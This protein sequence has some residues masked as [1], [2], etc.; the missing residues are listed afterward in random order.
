MKLFSLFTALVGS[1]DR[2]IRLADIVRSVVEPPTDPI[3]HIS[4]TR[5]NQRL[6]HRP[7]VKVGFLMEGPDMK[8]YSALFQTS[9]SV[10]YAKAWTS[11]KLGLPVYSSEP[12]E[13]AA[14][15][16]R[17]GEG[18]LNEDY[19]ILGPSRFLQIGEKIIAE[20]NRT[21]SEYACIFNG[22]ESFAFPISL[23]LIVE[24]S[25]STDKT[26]VADFL[27]GASPTSDFA[28][29]V[30]VFV[31]ADA[32]R[33]LFIGEETVEMVETLCYG[34]KTF[35]YFPTFSDPDAWI[36]EGSIGGID[37]AFELSTGAYSP[38]H[39]LEVDPQIID[40]VTQ[41]LLANNARQSLVNGMFSFCTNEAV[42]ALPTID[43]QFGREDDNPVIL[44]FSPNEYVIHQKFTQRCMLLLS[45]Q[46]GTMILGPK[47]L[48]KI[49][50]V[51]DAYR[52]R[53]GICLANIE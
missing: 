1:S 41:I 43:L 48:N 35:S 19:D 33:E 3:A 10:S 44:S 42:A 27:I 26:R 25:G 16:A 45:P 23:D 14:R 2:E 40:Q 22:N 12:G 28:N 13:I 18:Y 53:V 4:L 6:D 15:P 9:S 30:K 7:Y 21:V 51:F 38:N 50:T 8:G 37:C 36:I 47:I 52:K 29:F 24:F 49:V 32:S 31:L 5:S 46:I 39:L 11:P 17:N 20:S 34:G